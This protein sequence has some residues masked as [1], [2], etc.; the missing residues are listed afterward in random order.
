ML[1]FRIKN[2]ESFLEFA[3]DLDTKYKFYEIVENS[4]K[5]YIFG[6]THL[7]SNVIDNV[8]QKTIMKLVKEGFVEIELL[9]T[10]KDMEGMMS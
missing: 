1:D 8:D 9:E 2:L 7:I 6:R 5:L 3:A 4:I 10:K